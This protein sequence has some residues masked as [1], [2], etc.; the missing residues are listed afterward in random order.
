MG[1]VDEDEGLGGDGAM[2]LDGSSIVSATD[3]QGASRL[4]ISEEVKRIVPGEAKLP[5]SI[6]KKL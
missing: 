6:L 3:L 4:V 5:E 2:T 1:D